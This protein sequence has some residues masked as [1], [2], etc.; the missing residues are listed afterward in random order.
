MVTGTL[1][2]MHVLAATEPA[3]TNN[4]RADLVTIIG[5]SSFAIHCTKRFSSPVYANQCC[6]RFLEGRERWIVEVDEESEWVSLEG[7][8]KKTKWR[9]QDMIGFKMGRTL[10]STS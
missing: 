4:A 6:L 2:F 10:R 8:E 5:C 3:S 9:K 7:K 1:I